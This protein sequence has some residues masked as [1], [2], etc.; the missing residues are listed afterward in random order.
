M[1]ISGRGGEA[2]H[3]HQRRSVR[4]IPPL[5]FQPASLDI[6]RHGVMSTSNASLTNGPSVLRRLL[7]ELS[8]AGAT[9]R[10]YRDGGHGYENVLTAEVLQALDF[11]PRRRFLGQVL[12]SATGADE[13]RRLLVE[14]IEEAAVTLLPGSQHLIPSGA[15]HRY[16]LP[17]QPDGIIKGPRTYTIVEAK[18][19][20]ASSFKPEQ[21]AREYVLALRDAGECR[22][23]L[24]L[25]LG[26]APPVHVAGRGRLGIE[27]GISL[28]LK[29]VLTRAENHSFSFAEAHARIPEVVCWITWAEIARVV[30]NQLQ[31]P[32]G[33]DESVNRCIQRLCTTISEAVSWHSEKRATKAVAS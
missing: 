11:L 27:E 22:P 13:S 28:H 5:Y 2:P 14:E 19:I 7:A 25:M 29:S 6:R 23:L 3:L 20:H 1:L 21:L 30:Q 10:A 4:F 12:Q 16:R 18:R 15:H 8:W 9:I 33:H 26:E 17:V 24:L 32:D 31:H